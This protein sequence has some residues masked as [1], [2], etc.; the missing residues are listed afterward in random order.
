[1]PHAP[2][3]VGQGSPAPDRG[4]LLHDDADLLL[5][6]P[7]PG[8]GAA[9]GPVVPEVEDVPEDL[10]D[11]DIVLDPGIVAQD[12]V[13]EGAAAEAAETEL[14]IGGNLYAFHI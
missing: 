9:A 12:L 1:M 6:V 5:G 3:L 2:V 13:D 7:E 4:G 10:A 14:E 8:D 11:I